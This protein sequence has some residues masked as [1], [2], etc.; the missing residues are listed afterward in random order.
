MSLG[1]ATEY[2]A[3]IHLRGGRI[4][5]V[6]LAPEGITALSWGRTLGDYSDASVTIAKKS[7]PRECLRRLADVV[8]SAGGI[9]PGVHAWSHELSIYRD[10][11]LVWQGPIWYPQENRDTITFDARDVLWW[12]DR[13]VLAAEL[14]AGDPD[15]GALLS[16]IM[17][18]TWPS[19]STADPNIAAYWEIT[20]PSGRRYHLDEP[21]C[22]GST[23]VGKLVRDICS[24]GIDQYTLGRKIYMVPTHRVLSRAPYR[25][26][27]ENFLGELEVREGGADF[28][29]ES[30]A[31]G[32]EDQQGDCA[33]Y[34]VY[35]AGG[36]VSEWFGR[37]SQW[38]QSSD[39]NDP[40][41]LTEMAR[42][43][44][45]YGWPPPR[46]VVV[47]NGSRLSP[48]AAVNLGQLV[49]GRPFRVLLPNYIYG[50]STL[51]RLNE[52]GVSWSPPAPESVQI[53]LVSLNQPPEGG[54][55]P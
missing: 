47:P 29:T 45:E 34:G 10:N 39:T 21:V 32:K 31:Y 50:T 24:V 5:W 54:T 38:R 18:T 52:V 40:G 48:E 17:T 6:P 35:P 49:P 26:H 20:N 37:V 44:R 16:R 14:N 43:T 3:V 13:A 9:D 41:T 25:L 46:A 8:N 2:S 55:P 11:A 22:A 27:E 19:G 33:N 36:H 51:F 23:Y 30:Y 1:C 4:I 42:E 12:N 28:A 7:Q 15:A 53:S